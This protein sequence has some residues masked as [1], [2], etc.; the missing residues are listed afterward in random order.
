MKHTFTIL[1]LVCAM[2]CMPA[3]AFCN[4]LY[5]IPADASGKLVVDAD[6]DYPD[7][8]ALAES[9]AE[10]YTVDGVELPS[11]KFAIYAY[12][13]DTQE[14]TFYAPPYWAVSPIPP[15]YPSPLILATTGSLISLAESGTY[16]LEF[17]SRNI[18][19]ISSHMLIARPTAS[20][21]AH[22]PAQIYL[23]GSGSDVVTITGNPHEGIYYALVT[24]PASFKISYEPRVSEDAFIFG[25]SGGASGNVTLKADEAVAIAYATGTDANFTVEPSAIKAQTTHLVVNLASGYIEA[26]SETPTGIETLKVSMPHSEYYTLTGIPLHSEPRTSG[27]YLRLQNGSVSKILI[28]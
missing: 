10:V 9:E 22:Y 3:A 19:G 8:V 13:D 16:D 7:K 24:P 21:M 2:V 5:V 20:D 14:S 6:G 18:E 25:P 11:G 17:Y 27:V 12:A 26:F 1:A 15:S 28:P 23:V 4:T